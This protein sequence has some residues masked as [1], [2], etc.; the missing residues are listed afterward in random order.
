MKKGKLIRYASIL[1]F[2]L[3]CIQSVPLYAAE[4]EDY[5]LVP[6]Y[7]KRD[8]APNIMMLMDVS[9]DMNGPAYPGTYVPYDASDPIHTTKTGYFNP[10]GCYKVD[11]TKFV[12]EYKSTSPNISYTFT[13]P[14]PSSAPFRGNLM[15]WATMSKFDILEKVIIGGNTTSKQ[16][17]A[18]TLGG[19][20]GTWTDRTYGGC[21]FRMDAGKFIITE[22]SPEACPLLFSTPVPIASL[23]NA[24][25][26]IL[27]AMR[28]TGDRVPAAE[29]SG[30]LKNVSSG[31]SGITKKIVDFA[32]NI[33]NNI[34]FVSEAEAACTLSQSLDSSLTATVGTAYDFKLI[35]SGGA[36]NDPFVWNLTTKPSWLSGPTF[37]A[38]GDSNKHAK[39]TWS[40]TP[41]VAGNAT[42]TGTLAKTGCTTIDFSYVIAI[43]CPSNPII[44]TA[45]LD[46]GYVGQAYS[47]SAMAGRNGYNA[48]WS[49]TGLPPGLS[50]SSAGVISGTPTTCGTYNSVVV[51]YTDAAPCTSSEISKTLSMTITNGLAI[52]QPAG[53]SL[54]DGQTTQPYTYQLLGSGGTGSYTWSISSYCAGASPPPV[55]CLPFG[56]SLNA[57]T[58]LISGTPV[59]GQGG[60]TFNFRVTLTDTSTNCTMPYKDVT[61]HLEIWSTALNINSLCPP[62]AIKRDPYSYTVTAQSGTL[63]YH[64]DNLLSGGTCDGTTCTGGGLPAGI[65][66]DQATG[67]ISGTA[68]NTTS[69][70]AITIRVTDSAATPATATQSCTFQVVASTALKLTNFGALRVDMIE[71]TFTDSNGN[72]IYD[73]GTND[74]FNLAN[75]LNGNGKWDGKQGVFQKYYSSTDPKARWGLTNYNNSGV[76]ISPSGCIPVSPASAFY[77]NFQNI[78]IRNSQLSDGL[79]AD[80]SYYGQGH[81][82]G[83]PVSDPYAG[84]CGDPIDNLK[85]RKNFVLIITA[86]ADVAGSNFNKPTC[87]SVTNYNAPLVQN[88]CFGFNTDLRDDKDGKQ[89]VL[90]YIVNTMGN[91]NN[92]ILDDAAKAGGGKF[93]NAATASDLEAQLDQA[94]KDILSRAASGTAA[95]VLASGEGQGANLVQAVFYPRTQKI[96]AG[97]IFDTEVSWIGRLTNLWY[98]VDPF[99]KNSSIREDTIQ[100]SP[101]RKLNLVDDFAAQ[102][103][104]DSA[105]EQTKASRCEDTNGD[106]SIDDDN[107]GI[108][109]SPKPT[110]TLENLGNLWE[111][112]LELWRRDLSASPRTIYTTTGSDSD[113]DGHPDRIL[114]SEGNA[115]ALQTY[116]QAADANEAQAIIKYMHGEDNPVV[117]GTPYPYRERSTGI[118]INGVIESAKVWKLADVLNSTPK[119]ASWIPMNTYDQV[120]GDTSYGTYLNSSDYQNRGMMF[121]GANDGM[122]HA[123]KL[124]SLNLP[125]HNSATPTCSFVSKDVACLSGTELGKEVWAFIPKNAL[126]YLKYYA[127]QGYCHIY[128]VDLTPYVFDASI[129][130]GSTD[131]SND[132]KPNDGTTWRTIVIAGM[133]FGGACRNYNDVC[134]DCVKTPIDGV[135]YSSYFALDITNQNTP[136]LLWEFSD[137]ELGFTTTGP[138]VVKIG[139]D[140]NK[141]GK[142][143]VVFGSGPTGPISADAQ[144]FL[145]R[146]DQELKLFVFDL[147]QGPGT[148]NLNVTKIPTGI[149]YAFAGSMLN[150]THDFN[151][152]YQD[153][154]I[155]IPYVKKDPIAGTWTQGGV[156][157]L[158]TNGSSS[159]GAS[160]GGWAWSKVIDNIGPVTSSVVRLQH[161][162]KK[163]LWLFF[164]TGRYYFEQ[165]STVDDQDGQRHLFGITEPCFENGALS[166]GCVTSRTIGQLTPVN[167]TGTSGVSDPEGWYI[168]LDA[169][170]GSYRAERVI[171]DPLSTTTGLVFF[172]T[173]KPY[174]DVCSYGGKSFIWSVKYDTGAA[175]GALLKG[176]ALL[177]VSTGSIEQ[178]NLSTAFTEKGE[179]RTSALEGVPPTSQGLSL[180]S[181]PPP[182]KR[183]IHMR[184]R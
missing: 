66:L 89:N 148:N 183:T 143:F 56:L 140:R 3:F 173:Y 84:N 87:T 160:P 139:T 130:T 121:A 95:S 126:P 41:D 181:T 113:S 162:T 55:N 33:W 99:F 40:G 91:Y 36:A 101:Y 131:I 146:S 15:N 67:V 150:A 134:T 108:C 184:E 49:A 13:D 39:P 152:D 24:P 44:D 180:I 169:S 102:L 72:D 18:H 151:L 129:G 21:V 76:L 57:G 122:L 132:A 74:T 6:P 25:G 115:A 2:I 8:V 105:A 98:Y 176:M 153:D 64:W 147:K 174:N 17:N 59:Y 69:S 157:R 138:S 93:Y 124:G 37:P 107:N 179:R 14:C 78:Q 5:C 71:E 97:G 29:I 154:A 4:M 22:T 27:V 103:Y 88:G 19:I 116:L 28:N 85:C 156:G 128:S 175:P 159:P 120:Y 23:K 166:A 73:P 48:T 34:H 114:F 35:G 92:S 77:T 178:V 81:F 158:L 94:F 137:S 161:K 52:T 141:N 163:T 171:T 51:T 136:I 170:A 155:Y 112:G 63:P 100:E 145:G 42:V 54:S 118:K 43:S 96:E 149:E 90:T 47:G 38:S 165:V 12:E 117:S 11:G 65:S 62:A 172:T 164:G 119:I 167:L 80:I 110:V 109:D 60:Q 31:L 106:G 133:R 177:Q 58:G 144:Q 70:V 53:T 182:V 46:T 75:D 9:E 30:D 127:D 111:A 16:S 123:F 10:P 7:V 142:W 1:L 45:S 79:Y 86:G 83:A 50:M 104:F 125:S 61:L 32:S 82:T 168:N 68:P 20:S 135:G 26:N